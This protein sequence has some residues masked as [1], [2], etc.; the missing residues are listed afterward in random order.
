MNAA[1]GELNECIIQMKD[2][3]HKNK[4]V[5]YNSYFY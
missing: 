5:P 4:F 3:V 1:V 2:K